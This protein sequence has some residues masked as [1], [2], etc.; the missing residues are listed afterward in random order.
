MQVLT[1]DERDDTEERVHDVQA[2]SHDFLEDWS[3]YADPVVLT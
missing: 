3:R 1:Q 2:P